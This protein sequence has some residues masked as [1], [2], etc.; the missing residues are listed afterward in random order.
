[1]ANLLSAA[2]SIDFDRSLRSANIGAVAHLG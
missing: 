1:L 2:Q